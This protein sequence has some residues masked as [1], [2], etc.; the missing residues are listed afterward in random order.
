MR[1]ESRCVRVVVLALSLGAGTAWAAEPAGAPETVVVPSGSVTL[2]GLLWRPAGRGPFPA[3]LFNHGSGPAK[4]PSGPRILGPLFAEHGY[5]F[6]FLYRRGAGLSADQGVPASEQ[7]ERARA[8][9]KE[10]RQRLQLRLLEGEG[11]DDVLAGVALL[12]KR[13][14]VDARRLAVSGHSF[15][16][17]LSLLAAERDP[18]LRAVVDFAGAAMSWDGSAA[19]RER[20][21]SAAGKIEAP[22]FFIHAAND[23]SVAPAEVLSAERKRLGKPQRVGIYPALGSGAAAGHDFVYRGTDSWAPDVFPFLDGALHPA[24]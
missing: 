24:P 22:V 6:L 23:Y 17:I 20:L 7:L 8:S 10:A 19:L 9:G 14:E 1:P 4:D 21:L 18:G 12:R 5:V 15:G 13:P 16:G 3:V 2:R 11:L